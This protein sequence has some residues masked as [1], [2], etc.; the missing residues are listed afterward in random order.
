MLYFYFGNDQKK[1]SDS[2]MSTVGKLRARA[3]DASIERITDEAEVLDLDA[4]LASSGLFHATR[5]VIF[6]GVC[7]KENL[8][9]ELFERLKDIEESEHVFFI[10]ETKLPAADFKKIEKIA[11]KT[12]EHSMADK[13][14]KPFNTFALSDA[15]LSRDTK[16][17]WITLQQALRDGS[18]AE[19]LHGILF[20]GAKSLSLA[21]VS[22]NAKEAGMHP[23]VYQK[24]Q[25]AVS[26][27]KP[28]EISN[29]VA[30]LSELPHESRR[31][32]VELEYALERFVLDR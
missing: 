11:V 30:S 29:L 8:K 3:P 24:T 19:E 21:S 22:G 9:T 12:I 27:F 20:W 10:R 7:S 26:K 28:E 25:S 2:L 23:F 13:K 4:L 5:L 32:G 18:S 1:T 16:K 6:D 15:L 31:K 17:L 14:E